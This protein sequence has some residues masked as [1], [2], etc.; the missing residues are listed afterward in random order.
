MKLIT[1][2][3]AIAILSAS[4]AIAAGRT[5]DC[6]IS[7][8]PGNEVQFKGKCNFV[9]EAGGSFTLMDAAGRDKLYDNVGMVSVYVTGKDTAEVSGLVLDNSGGHNSR[10]GSAKRSR[11]DRA[12]WDGDDFRV[13]AW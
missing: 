2:L 10:W 6:S 3:T 7:T 12:C 5:V 8:L 9:P 4:V 13:C 11:L 1:A